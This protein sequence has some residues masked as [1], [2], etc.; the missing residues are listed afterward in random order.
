MALPDGTGD[1]AC[2]RTLERELPEVP[3][4]ARPELVFFYLAGVDVVGTDRL[5]RLTLTREELAARQVLSGAGH[6]MTT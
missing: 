1:E 3:R 5:E 4:E 2:L 6:A